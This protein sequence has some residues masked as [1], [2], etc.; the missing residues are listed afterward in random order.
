[1]CDGDAYT[2]SRR[3]RELALLLKVKSR[4]CGWD[5]LQRSCRLR[6]V[7]NSLRALD[8]DSLSRRAGALSIA[9][10]VRL[11]S[12]NMKSGGFALVKCQVV[13]SM[14]QKLWCSAISFGA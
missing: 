9:S 11:K 1:M 13:R 6:E 3:D 4:S 5:C 8:A 10:S 7:L 12:P 14:F 2:L